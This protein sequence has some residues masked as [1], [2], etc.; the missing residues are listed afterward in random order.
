[1]VVGVEVGPTLLREYSSRLVEDQAGPDKVKV[2]LVN[3][4]TNARCEFEEGRSGR[5]IGSLMGPDDSYTVRPRP[6]FGSLSEIRTGHWYSPTEVSS[7]AEVETDELAGPLNDRDLLDCAEGESEAEKVSV[8]RPEG[9]FPARSI[10]IQP[11]A[12][13]DWAYM[14][15]YVLY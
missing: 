11:C 3:L 8:H 15:H 4:T 10:F 12:V 6:P 7:K 14:D 13:N 2:T 1:M 5:E 9:G